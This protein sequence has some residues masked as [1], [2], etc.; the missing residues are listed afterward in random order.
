M[1]RSGG[2]GGIAFGI[3]VGAGAVWT[4]IEWRRAP[5]DGFAAS[6]ARLQSLEARLISIETQQRTLAN[7]PWLATEGGA[8]LGAAKGRPEGVTPLRADAVAYHAGSAGALGGKPV[9]ENDA[10]VRRREGVEES[11]MARALDKASRL[12]AALGE[13]GAH[14]PI[15]SPTAASAASGG[16]GFGSEPVNAALI[17]SVAD[18]AAEATRGPD[19]EAVTHAFNA[20]LKDAGLDRWYLLSAEPLVADHALGAVTLAVRGVRGTATGSLVAERL[21]LERDP[22]TGVAAFVASGAHGIED[23]IEVHYEGSRYRI[24]IP[25]VLPVELVPAELRELFALG[26]PPP[27]GAAFERGAAV[28]LVN[29]VLELE[30]AFVLRLREI[31]KFEGERFV[32]AVIDLDFDEEGKARQTVLADEAWFEL[33]PAARYGEL[34]CEGGV[35]IEK[36]QK[37]PLFRGHLRIPLR[38]L[39]P[40]HWKGVPGVH[41]VIGQ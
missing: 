22:I 8:T 2:I 12:S 36:G 33:D 27:A 3:L 30:K 40:E 32:K 4:A 29:R 28:A 20:L 13:V 37:R 34:C 5:S 9:E 25:G 7:L 38:D 21:M 18:A 6:E 19:P 17:P 16:G 39:T 11:V 15:A 10:A 31:E 26:A 1:A 35:M 14:L 41:R 23:G 24:E